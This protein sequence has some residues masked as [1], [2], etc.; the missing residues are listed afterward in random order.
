MV[1]TVTR[2]M[3]GDDKVASMTDGKREMAEFANGNGI[4]LSRSLSSGSTDT[5]VVIIEEGPTEM[6][7]VIIMMAQ[8]KFQ[9]Y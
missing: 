5:I 6:G 4:N 1:T 9:D 2:T 3:R 8:S 7:M